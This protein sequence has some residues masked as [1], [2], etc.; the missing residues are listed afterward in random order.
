MSRT[1]I[2]LGLL[3]AVV[4]TTR[5]LAPGAFARVFAPIAYV[6][7]S[8]LAGFAAGA[9]SL[10]DPAALARERDDALRYGATMEEQNRVLAARVKDLETLLGGRTEPAKG[11][12]AYVLARPPQSPYDT[13]VVDQG[14]DSGV[15]VGGLVTSAGGIPVGRIA[16]VTRTSARVLLYSAPG[17]S[18]EAWAG[19]ART[20]FALMGAGGGAYEA[21]AP[22][23][24]ILN[25]GDLIYASLS[26]S[27]PIGAIRRIDT[28]PANPAK[29]V[30]VEPV[31]N[32]FSIASVI[33]YPPVTLP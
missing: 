31:T 27:I 5:L 9:A 28:D 8:A 11:T 18:T 1:G 29:I 30:H 23:D 24:A 26:G 17:L 12:V 21:S 14:T 13:L 32:P 6:S 22:R 25:E 3:V 7:D 15:G 10:S 2:V 16:S 4:V 33:I 20:A 19:E